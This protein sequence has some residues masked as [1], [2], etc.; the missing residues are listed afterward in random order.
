M[1]GRALPATKLLVTV[2]SMGILAL[3]LLAWARSQSGPMVKTVAMSGQLRKLFDSREAAV[4]PALPKPGEPGFPGPLV[5]EP[6][7][8]ATA[9]LLYPMLEIGGCVFDPRMVYRREP[10]R[11]RVYFLAEHARGT[12]ESRTNSLGMKEREEPSGDPPDLRV[13]VAG[14]SNVEGVCSNE[15][16]AA[17]LLEG[18]LRGRLS[19]MDVETLNTGTGGYDF[20][21]VLGVL[22]AYRELRPDVF[23]VIAYGGN[24]FF[25]SVRTFRYFERMPAP[26]PPVRSLDL[27]TED[28]DAFTRNLP[29]AEVSQAVFLR[30]F[31]EDFDIAVEAACSATAEMQRICGQIGARLVCAYLPPPLQGQPGSFGPLRDRVCRALELTPSDLAVSDR[32]AD[33]WLAFLE[34]RGIA[35]VDLRPRFRASSRRLYWVTDTHLD[36]EGQ[37]VVAEALLPL[38][39]EG[40]P[41]VRAGG[42]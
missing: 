1:T 11:S 9:R 40:L 31:P 29:A 41:G 12:Y 27:L 3:A 32:I 26:Q 28:P 22:E 17:S 38:V 7:D 13:L 37:R 25:S 2:A 24:D 5:R 14:A 39:L 35:H 23:V 6:L 34:S 19:G 16:T 36:V 21:N 30:E 15:E 42:R 8:P 33:C 20:Y 10:D 18:L 4:L